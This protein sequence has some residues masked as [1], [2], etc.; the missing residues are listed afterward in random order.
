MKTSSGIIEELYQLA[1]REL[2][3]IAFQIFLYDPISD[4]FTAQP[5]RLKTADAQFDQ[6]KF[7]AI[8][9]PTQKENFAKPGFFSR[10]GEI[11]LPLI[12]QGR[13][14]GWFYLPTGSSQI[15]GVED[16]L[17]QLNTAM[18]E[19][20]AN[21]GQIYT[22]QDL[23]RKNH[24]LGIL[25]RIAQG[26]NITIHFDDM[27]ELIYAQTIQVIPADVF[28]ILLYNM[29]EDLY[30]YV[31]YLEKEERVGRKENIPLTGPETIE[32][33][34]IQTRKAFLS[35]SPA[36]TCAQMD[37]PIPP[38]G[39]RAALCVPLNSG[40]DTIGCLFLGKSSDSPP[41]SNRQKEY[42]QAIADQTASAIVKSQLIATMERRA[43][44]LTRLN[45]AARRLN[46]T[47]E[48]DPLLKMILES[49][50][51][52][53]GSGQGNLLLVDDTSGELTNK[54][55]I[56]PPGQVGVGL[57]DAATL[58]V[59][60]EVNQR[61]IGAMELATNPGASPL[62][63][64]DQKL[65]SAFA[66]QAA[67]AIQNARLY[68]LTDK[69][70]ASRIEELSVMQ[71]IDLELN[72]NID[73]ERTLSITLE[74]A[75]QVSGFSAGLI[76]LVNT[77]EPTFWHV[78]DPNL[79]TRDNIARF[80][81]SLSKVT[82]GNETLLLNRQHDPD[83]PFLMESSTLQLLTPIKQD[84]LLVIETNQV[85]KNL[86]DTRAFLSRLADHAAIAITNGQLF[87]QIR[88]ANLAK[89][90][91][92][93][94][95]AHELKNP[96]TSIKGYS[97]LMAAGA[98][99]PLTE[100][101]SGFLHTIHTNVERM[102][103]IVEDLN[104]I[105]KIEAG[106][107]RLDFNRVNIQDLIESVLNSTRRQAGDK[108]QNLTTSLS[109]ELMPVWVDKTR[110][111]QILV[112]LVS[113]AIKYT[114]DGGQIQLAAEDGMDG[115]VV[116]SVK[117]NGIGISAEDQTRIFTKFF[118]SEDDR[119]RKSTGAGLGLNITKN[120]V[121]MQGGE[122]WFKSQYNLGTTFFV[123]LPTIEK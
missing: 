112:N 53:V 16:K 90:E 105:T 97:E 79:A 58:T 26:I 75:L 51:Q 70:L 45:D 84:G 11:Y 66:S 83:V 13:L 24:E 42:L 27:L 10:E 35:N 63:E 123:A 31:F 6:P 46:S 115:R 14:L 99:G 34:V 54:V 87:N 95:V 25:S 106:R 78:S 93:S 8:A 40:A 77:G 37:L 1:E 111:E 49:A 88:D 67:T 56:N 17:A 114:P 44:Q 20:V 68:T 85:P 72:A 18:A 113:N 65:L 73:L 59:P 7:E 69:N 76:T 5:R 122:I 86:D 74:R 39:L 89:S 15:I 21:L 38:V 107:L 57:E 98:V 62:H 121:E 71:Q 64:E 55:S 116:I 52:L 104:D 2:A 33:R 91:F 48:L 120:L 94:F 103:A 109:G 61:V 19:N 41:Y 117:D 47:L 92:V 3:G 28:R 9:D 96:M 50:L 108:K 23:E 110:T 100:D 36:Q 4:S 12:Q 32:Q 101:Q 30:S 80:L 119:A 102:R 82:V 43:R 60:L 29:Q 81:P 22:D 118:R